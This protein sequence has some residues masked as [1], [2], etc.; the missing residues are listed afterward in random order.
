M[1][2]YYSP[3]SVDFVKSL[4]K[5]FGADLEL[6]NCAKTNPASCRYGKSF[7]VSLLV[8]ASLTESVRKWRRS[9]LQRGDVVDRWPV[10][11]ERRWLKEIE[12][13]LEEQKIDLLRQCVN[14]QRPFEKIESQGEI[15]RLFGLESTLRPRGRPRAESS[16]SRFCS[17]CSANYEGTCFLAALRETKGGSAWLSP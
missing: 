8:R 1:V 10:D 6:C 12:A 5:R 16:L 17:Y 13:P 4:T 15:A 11:G 9:S 14:R 2:G 7:A 3:S